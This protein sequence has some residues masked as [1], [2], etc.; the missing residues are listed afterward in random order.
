MPTRP[1][2]LI[3]DDNPKSVEA[4]GHI[5]ADTNDV[6]YALSGQEAIAL[7]AR[8][9]P[10]LILLDVLMPEMDGYEVCAALKSDP[11]SRDV[12][13]IFV[14]AKNH[15]QDEVRALELGAADFLHKPVVRQV[16]QARVRLQLALRARERE[17]VQLSASLEQRVIDRT[18]ALSDALVRAEAANR[19]KTAFLSKM[20][21]EF[22][23]PMNAIIGFAHLLD[24][25]ATTIQARNRIARVRDAAERLLKILNDTLDI[26]RLEAGKVRIEAIDF[27]LGQLLDTAEG[28]WREDAVAKGLKL[29]REVD[30][31]LPGTLCGDP[32]RLRQVLETLIGNAI[33]FSDHGNVTLRVRLIEATPD[34][35]FIRFEVEDEG[36]GIGE[37]ERATLFNAFE[38][39]DNTITRKFGGTGLGLAICRHLTRAMGGTIGVTSTPGRGSLF[40]VNLHLRRS[41]ERAATPAQEAAKKLASEPADDIDQGREHAQQSMDRLASLLARDDLEAQAT[42]QQNAESVAI[43]L[44]EKAESFSRAMES[45]DFARALQLLRASTT[46]P[47]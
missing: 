14:T 44:G 9:L 26:A 28:A 42:W 4:L 18:Q 47:K 16:V 23:T 41:A 45:F 17:L 29:T 22:R 40:W 27:P 36:P 5:L 46:A 24:R 34:A 43:A 39:A 19:A 35:V 3:V 10:D 15:P 38:Q 31:G 12:P 7:V 20:S 21:H 1:L 32:M 33:K 11:R 30:P 8:T 37:Q 13:I 25:E 2:V 6:Q